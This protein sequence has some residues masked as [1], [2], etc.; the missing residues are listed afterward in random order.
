MNF[1]SKPAALVILGLT[2]LTCSRAMFFFFNDPEGPNLLVVVVAA[3]IIYF[4]SWATY[5]AILKLFSLAPRTWPK[6]VLLVILVQVIITT[7]L[8]LC[9]S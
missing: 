8:Y 7:F 4:L 3:T 5:K 1:K 6:D 9:L 2:A